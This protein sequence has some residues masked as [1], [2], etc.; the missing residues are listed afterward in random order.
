VCSIFVDPDAPSRD[1]PTVREW[2]HWLVVNVPGDSKDISKG[3]TLIDFVP[4]SPGE[5][6]GLHR[7][8]F[9]LYEQPSFLEFEGAPRFDR[10]VEH[11]A[12][13][14]NFSIRNFANQYGLGEQ[15]WAG[16]F[17][18]TEWDPYVKVVRKQLGLD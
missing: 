7:Y 14:R 17:Y 12:L 4:S 5:S 10:S 13:R 2:V 9:V 6:S 16:N 3:R 15:A 8:T 11:R 1:T 18:V